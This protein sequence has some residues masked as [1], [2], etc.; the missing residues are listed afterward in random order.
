MQCKFSMK[1]VCRIWHNL[2][3]SLFFWVRTPLSEK[4]LLRN[5]RESS[6]TCKSAL[7]RWCDMTRSLHTFCRDKLRKNGIAILWSLFTM[8]F[9][10]LKSF[11]CKNCF[12]QNVNPFVGQDNYRITTSTDIFGP[13]Y[14]TVINYGET[15]QQSSAFDCVRRILVN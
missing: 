15:W 2:V 9:S 11:Y 4:S 3:A 7:P 1:S 6:N 13:C 5:M 12:Y 14:S 10:L 8:T